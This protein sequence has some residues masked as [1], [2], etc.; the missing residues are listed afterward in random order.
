MKL[1]FFLLLLTAG[2]SSK[3]QW[4]GKRSMEGNWS[5][6]YITS[7]SSYWEN[8]KISIEQNPDKSY[9]ARSYTKAKDTIVVCRMECKLIGSDSLV[10]TEIEI[11]K[12]AGLKP[13]TCFQV[14]ELK[15]RGGGVHQ[16]KELVGKWYCNHK[17]SEGNG[18]IKLTKSYR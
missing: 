12:P 7:D 13:G 5:G 8:I 10:L 9:S 18:F 4:Q 16:P 3:A 14:M 6:V 17:K 15:Y 2:Y 11:I 1:L